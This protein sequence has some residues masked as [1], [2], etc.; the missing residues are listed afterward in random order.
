MTVVTSLRVQKKEAT[1]QRILGTALRLFSKS[2]FEKP[3]VEEI[4]AAAG[5]GKGTIY[6]YF[7]TKE[8]ILVAFM[9][10]QEERVQERVRRMLTRDLDAASLL[11]LYLR[12]HFKLKRPYRQFSRV[13]LSQIIMRGAEI[14]PYIDAM[15]PTVDKTLKSLFEHLC[16]RGRIRKD[17]DIEGT[18][19]AFKTMHLGISAVWAMRNL[20]GHQTDELCEGSV[21]L[22]CR[23][24]ER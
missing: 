15:Q 11:T 17:V 19:L 21:R 3:T 16:V 13:F 10:Q 14:A 24:L 8:D 2:G 4:A 12:E 6:N 9:C 18:I 1:R 20:T 23:G 7:R 5:V 22:F